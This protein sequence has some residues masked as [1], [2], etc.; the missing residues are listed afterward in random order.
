[1]EAA[2][3]RAAVEVLDTTVVVH[4]LEAAEAAEVVIVAQELPVP[5]T[6]EEQAG[7]PMFTHRVMEALEDMVQEPMGRQAQYPAEQELVAAAVDLAPEPASQDSTEA[8]ADSTAV[9]V[10]AGA[11]RSRV[12]VQEELVLT[13]TSL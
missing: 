10:E 3:P 8:T 12:E 11:A 4:T 6:L 5:H 2:A 1:M 13:D 9:P 7:V